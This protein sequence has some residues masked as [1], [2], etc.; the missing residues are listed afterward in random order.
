MNGGGDEEGGSDQGCGVGVFTVPACGDERLLRFHVVDFTYTH[1][2]RR[3]AFSTR[4]LGMLVLP[5]ILSVLVCS[6]QIKHKSFN[7]LESGR[8]IQQLSPQQV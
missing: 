6:A 5:A 4:G 1:H 2:M 3:S 7:A 8:R